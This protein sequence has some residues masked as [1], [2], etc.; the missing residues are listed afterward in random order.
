MRILILG[1]TGLTG[2]FTVQGLAEKGHEVTIF[3]RGKT[4]AD[5]PANV[6]QIYGDKE[7]LADFTETF[8]QVAPEV[9]VNMV[10]FT[11]QDARTF[12]E[13][14]RSIARRTVVISSIDVYRAY[15]RLHRTEAGLRDPVPLTE[16]A[17]LREQLSIHGSDYD[18]TNVERIVMNDPDLPGTILR[19]PAVYGPGDTLHRLYP[20]A[21]RMADRRHF[22]LIQED[23][24]S[25]RFSHGY[26]EDVAMAT[27]LAATQERA[28]GRVYNVAEQSTSPQS[29]WGK[30]IGESV[31]WNF[32]V[33]TVP[34]EQL[35]VALV[36]DI[37]FRQDWVVDTTR[38]R[39]ELGYREIV[40]VEEGIRR[41]VAWERANPPEKAAPEWF[42]YAAEDKVL[43][44]V[45][46][47]V[48]A[49]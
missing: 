6:A 21:K 7:N 47:T 28:A 9:V 11:A 42:D 24:A 29:V 5:L 14:F 2:P 18:K 36:Q 22:L 13:V 25:W 45:K 16:E 3:H 49:S 30:K 12:M 41:T 8:R 26:V 10:A 20:F 44:E 43:A 27:V 48:D 46:R 38:I 33:V 19:F 34:K 32:E 35:P 37:D 15:G 31:G 40:S 1:G 4:Q 39:D 17:P 23:Y